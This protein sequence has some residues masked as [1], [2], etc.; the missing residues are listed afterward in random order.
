MKRTLIALAGLL[1][2]VAAA[3]SLQAH[4]NFDLTGK[5]VKYE[6]PTLTVA[7]NE[8]GTIKLKCEADFATI[9]YQGKDATVDDLKPGRSVIINAWGDNLEEAEVLEIDVDP[10]KAAPKAPAKNSTSQK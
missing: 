2:L 1:L 5:I 9:K 4:V 10:P 7:T 3:A 8:H 6:K